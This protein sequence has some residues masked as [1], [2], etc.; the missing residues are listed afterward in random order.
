MILQDDYDP[1]IIEAFRAQPSEMSLIAA[2]RAAF[3]QVFA[4]MSPLRRSR[5]SGSATG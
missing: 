3:K 4:E 5:R 1:R 2:L